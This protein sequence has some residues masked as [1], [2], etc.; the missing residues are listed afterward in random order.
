MNKWLAGLIIGVIAATSRSMPRRSVAWARKNLG[1][2]SPQVQQRQ[3]TPPLS[4][5]SR[6]RRRSPVRSR[7]RRPSSGRRAPGAAARPASPCAVR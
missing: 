2:Q 4:R 3:A 5:R 1:R 7:L 6:R